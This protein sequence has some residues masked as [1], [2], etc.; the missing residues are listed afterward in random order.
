MR[1]PGLAPP[2]I[3]STAIQCNTALTCNSFAWN[4]LLS[5]NSVCLFEATLLANALDPW[6]CCSD[7]LAFIFTTA[8]SKLILYFLS[9][10]NIPLTKRSESRKFWIY[11]LKTTNHDLLH[12]K[13]GQ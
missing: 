10:S 3:V 4:C 1:T 8:V 2:I 6:N 7:T 13:E 12:P 5:R 9:I 11:I